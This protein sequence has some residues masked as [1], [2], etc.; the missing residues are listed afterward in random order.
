M[1]KDKSI[2]NTTQYENIGNNSKQVVN[3]YIIDALLAS[4][5]SVKKKSESIDIVSFAF[6]IQSLE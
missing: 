5:K 2:S 1:N 6:L 3:P 4:K